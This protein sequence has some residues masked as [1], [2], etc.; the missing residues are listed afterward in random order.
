MMSAKLKAG[1]VVR[2]EV[3]CQVYDVLKIYA[4]QIGYDLP[5]IQRQLPNVPEG[6]VPTFHALIF[7]SKYYS[8][9]QLLDLA[10]LFKDT[11]G[12][13]LIEQASNQQTCRADPEL[14]QKITFHTP[15]QQRVDE[16]FEE[17]RQQLIQRK[18]LIQNYDQMKSIPNPP[19]V[20]GQNPGSP[21][22]QP[23]PSGGD[24]L[25]DLRRRL[26]GL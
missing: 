11:Y 4:E 22:D 24:D 3:R 8:I 12:K 13:A 21:G 9:K 1:E 20:G 25:D 18:S 7:A 16:I 6:M 23:A 10:D 5:L 15:E 26:A 2:M 19:S 17:V 14:I